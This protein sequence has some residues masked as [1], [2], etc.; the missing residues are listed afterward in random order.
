MKLR[1]T[2]LEDISRDVATSFHDWKTLKYH[3]RRILSVYGINS[4][5]RK[6]KPFLSVGNRKHRITWFHNLIHWTADQWE[7]VVFSHECR[8]GL[9]NDARS[10]RIWCTSAE[11]NDP[12]YFQPVFKNSVSIMFWGC[13]GPSGVGRLVFC[14]DSLNAT[15]YIAILQNNLL[16]LVEN[17]FGDDGRPFIF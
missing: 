3:I 2:T 4:R 11:A 13:I 9:K 6:R 1:F 7:Q 5:I 10:L 17:V 12:R 16:Q 15:K 14:E 8:F